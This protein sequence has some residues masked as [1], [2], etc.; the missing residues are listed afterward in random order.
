MYQAETRKKNLG[1]YEYFIAAYRDKYPKAN[2]CLTTDLENLF[3]FYDFPAVHWMHI[4]ATN[5]IESTFA[6]VRLRTK[7]TKSCGTYKATLSMIFK[8]AQEAQKNW[9]WFRGYK[10]I[11]LVLENRKFRD[12]KLVE[13]VA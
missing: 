5:P 4:R 7:Q 10:M 12:G 6:T 3:T 13:R 8:L 9:R 1:A 2:E 11:P